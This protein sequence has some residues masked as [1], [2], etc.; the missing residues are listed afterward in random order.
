MTIVN[1]PIQLQEL[2]NQVGDFIEYWGFKN[3]H[4]RL[5]THLY[6]SQEPLDAAG[7]IRRLGV[8]KAL[9]SMSLKDL[10][11][12]NVVRSAGKSATGTQLYEVNPDLSGIIVN[13]L[14]LREK[15]IIDRVAQATDNL[16]ALSPEQRTEWSVCADRVQALKD[17]IGTGMR[18][19]NS[20]LIHREQPQSDWQPLQLADA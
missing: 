5:W 6:L 7:L 3:I 19:L 12:F 4:G 14:R 18:T 16:E 8:S 9:I 1:T 2:A 13:V 11:K 10:T 15:R 20:I 17:L